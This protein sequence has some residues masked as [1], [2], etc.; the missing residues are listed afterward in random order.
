MDIHKASEYFNTGK[1]TGSYKQ[2]A[3][4]PRRGHQVSYL[5]YL[6]QT[7]FY[8]M[9]TTR[10]HTHKNLFITRMQAKTL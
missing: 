9:E 5:T 6:A 7:H 1:I 2:P 3:T 8:K 10:N 4:P